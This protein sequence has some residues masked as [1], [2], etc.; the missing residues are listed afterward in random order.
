MLKSTGQE[1]PPHTRREIVASSPKANG[2]MPERFE[3]CRGMKATVVINIAT[4]ADIANGTR[5]TI[6]D[7]VF[8]KREQPRNW[9][10]KAGDL[11]ILQFPPSVIFFQPDVPSSA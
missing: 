1:V 3:I 7:F 4:Q 9:L 10:K 2:N 8:D 11:I 6:V 5:G